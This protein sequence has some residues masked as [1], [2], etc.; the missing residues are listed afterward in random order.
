MR[1]EETQIIGAASTASTLAIL[2]G[3]HSKWARIE[4]GVIREF[5][6][7]MTGEVYAVLRHHSILGRLMPEGAATQ[8][9]ELGES[10][11]ERGVRMGLT[12]ERG[13]LGDLFSARVLP[14]IGEIE[15]GATAGYLSGL[16]VGSEI[17]GAC[18]ALGHPTSPPILI[19]EGA[20][21]ERYHR[22]LHLAGID[23]RSGPPDAA[24]LG[25]L[26]IAE[27]LGVSA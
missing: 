20:L 17:R 2:P 24:V 12:S 19:G 9:G 3:T 8:P 13:L 6:T 16:L 11:F 14:L 7:F 15:A 22:A 5:V 25:L 18:A 23:A 10:G 4:S 21:V 27:A 1:G 26:A